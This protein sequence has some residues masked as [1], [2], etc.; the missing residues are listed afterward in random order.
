[1]VVSLLRTLSA[2]ATLLQQIMRNVATDHLALGI[3][4]HLNEFAE[5]GRVVVSSSFCVAEGPPE[6]DWLG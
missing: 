3:I 4:V 5:S 1:M 2:D 6:R